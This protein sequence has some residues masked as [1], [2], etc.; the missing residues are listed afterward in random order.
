MIPFGI[1]DLFDAAFD[2]APRFAAHDSF[3][4]E[5]RLPARGVSSPADDTMNASERITADRPPAASVSK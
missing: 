5:S 3:D 2:A 1:Y 4:L